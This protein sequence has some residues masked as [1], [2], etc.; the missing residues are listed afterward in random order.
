[1]DMLMEQ[2]KT[3]KFH[4]LFR[5]LDVSS[6]LGYPAEFPCF[7]FRQYLMKQLII[8]NCDSQNKKLNKKERT[9]YL[10]NFICNAKSFCTA[11]AT[12]AAVS[13]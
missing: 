5:K 13:R 1:M 8:G 9:H 10:M 3:T 12:A 11:A 6:Y 7:N 4:S 2:L